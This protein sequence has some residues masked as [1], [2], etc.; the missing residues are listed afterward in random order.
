MWTRHVCSVGASANLGPTCYAV[1]PFSFVVFSF[2]APF[3]AASG[4]GGSASDGT[5]RLCAV[6]VTD[7]SWRDGRSPGPAVVGVAPS[8]PV[9]S[10]G[11]GEQTRGIFLPVIWQEF[12][13]M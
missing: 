13:W 2:P 1:V 11:A 5:G 6:V 12:V 3:N 4:S 8:P 7:V 9:S 10:D